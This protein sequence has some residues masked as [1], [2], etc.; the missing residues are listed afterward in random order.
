MRSMKMPSRG[1]KPKYD[2]VIEKDVEIPMRDGAV[3]RGDVFR[4]KSAQRAPV[5]MNLGAYQ[6]DKI[7]L[8]PDEVDERANPHMNWE[9]ANP[10]WWV[11]RGYALVRVDSRG[12]GKSPG[13]NNPWSPSEARD[14]YDAI[15][16]VARAPWCNGRVGTLGISYYAM[17]QWLVANLRPPSLKAMIPWEGAA[18]MY[19][20]FAY[21]GGLF[22]FGFAVNWYH[23]QVAH[24]RLGKPRS[25]SPD[26]FSSPWLL[27]YLR[28]NLDSEWY[29]G[30]QARWSEI[31]IPFLSAGNW[32]G[33][34]LH[35]RGNCEAF[36]RA[37]S[38]HKWLR[39]DTGTH[40]GPFY[41]EEGRQDQLRFFDYWLKG[42]ETALLKEPRIKLRIR[43]GGKDNY[44]WR[45]ERNWPLK[46]TR[47]TR[48]YLNPVKVPAR[49]DADGTLTILAPRKATS[50]TYWS[51][52]LAQPGLGTPTWMSGMIGKSSPRTGISFETAPLDRNTEITG[53][54]ALVLWVASG[55]E[56]MDIYATI[57]NIDADGNDVFEQGQQGQPVPVAKGWLRASHRKLDPNLTLP[58]RPYH[59]H[60]ERLWLKPGE[61]VRVEVEIWPTCM[62]FAKGHRIRLDIQPRDGIGSAPYTH[63]SADYNCA[64]N[65]VFAGGSRAS[66][67][68]LPLIADR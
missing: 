24:H 43:K 41:S 50:L 25:T 26:G 39:I 66:Y 63:Y 57:R 62:V 58:Y 59:A 53:P 40:Y 20:D 32:S 35:L 67:L 23:A 34:G 64:T 30:R 7:W 44:E 38:R 28:E 14:F 11:P 6:K 17:N 65:T 27:E 22:S 60:T 55:T 8:P 47:W 19:R 42:V 52:G 68:L 3:L 37:A 51:N 5:I 4:P 49:Q 1:S 21:H 15:E 48:F 54:V 33:M 56:D 61:P 10:L 29:F 13:L 16:W 46:R 36:T 9:T 31:D 12:S 45:H 18:D 2:L